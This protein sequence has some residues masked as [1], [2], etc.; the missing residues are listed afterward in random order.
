[1]V[2]RYARRCTRRINFESVN[3]GRADTDTAKED[4]FAENVSNETGNVIVS[5]WRWTSRLFEWNRFHTRNGLCVQGIAHNDCE[6]S[7]RGHGLQRNVGH[8]IVGR[9]S[10]R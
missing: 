10:W 7:G 3:D 9:S 1:M 2:F 4:D 5:G 6:Y 8:R